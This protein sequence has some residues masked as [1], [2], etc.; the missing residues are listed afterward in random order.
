MASCLPVLPQGSGIC[1]RSIE[2]VSL[3][4]HKNPNFLGPVPKRGT[5]IRVLTKGAAFFEKVSQ[6]DPPTF[7]RSAEG[8]SG[9]QLK[10][11]CATLPSSCVE[12]RWPRMKLTLRYGSR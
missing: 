6:E 7:V 1:V 9:R 12:H 4:L 3:P 2:N 10:D 11:I 8:Q 5:G